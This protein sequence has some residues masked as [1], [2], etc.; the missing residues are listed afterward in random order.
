MMLKVA[1]IC[2]AKDFLYKLSIWSTTFNF[3]EAKKYKIC[4][5]L[6]YL[7]EVSQSLLFVYYLRICMINYSSELLKA[8]DKANY[9]DREELLHDGVIVRKPNAVVFSW[10][11]T[12]CRRVHPYLIFRN[13]LR[14]EL[15]DQ[16]VIELL[17][18]LKKH[19]IYTAIISN[20]DKH[21][22]NYEVQK[23]EL[24]DYFDKIVGGGDLKE[25]K[26]SIDCMISAIEDTKVKF[27]ENIWVIGDSEVE[28]KLAKISC[29]TGI[30]YDPCDF[31]HKQKKRIHSKFCFRVVSYKDLIK[32]VNRF[33]DVEKPLLQET[34]MDTENESSKN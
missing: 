23:L 25:E 8:L 6:D 1:K 29:S 16:N 7:N 22:L 26:P 19:K 12:I 2:R 5:F 21:K 14:F 20:R 34:V 17:E 13:N 30:L 15:I 9:F 3:M 18:V 10:G 31:Y 4:I 32:L 28:M 33:Y 27:G 11:G 24:V